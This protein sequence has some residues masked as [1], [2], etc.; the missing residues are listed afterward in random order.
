VNHGVLALIVI[1][2]AACP[3]LVNDFQVLVLVDSD[4]G[5]PFLVGKLDNLFERLTQVF[6]D[7][8]RVTVH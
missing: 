6:A 7:T 5:H 8:G 2:T 4:L 3:A 1:V